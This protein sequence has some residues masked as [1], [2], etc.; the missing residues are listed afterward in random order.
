MTTLNARQVSALV[1]MSR[2][3]VELGFG[4]N[5][6]ARRCACIIHNGSNPSAFA[7]T[8]SGLWRF[9]S[10]ER[11]GDKI[12]LVREVRHCSFRE[13]VEFLAALAGVEY[14]PR[15]VLRGTLERQKRHRERETAEADALLALE[16]VAW[17]GEARALV[18]QLEAIRRNAGKRL[19]AIHRGEQ[20]RWTG[21]TDL[22][23]E[24][25]AEVYRQLPRQWP[26]YNAISFARAEDRFAFA[27]DA[28]HV[29]R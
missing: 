9:H 29:E 1:V 21:E 22:V 20:E 11:G 23:W 15:L 2:L 24:A 10:C 13:A 7:W 26:L 3:L 12:A 27:M 28:E 6:R 16:F 14:R 5:R 4:V 8:D 19:Q 18:L 25:L 17:C